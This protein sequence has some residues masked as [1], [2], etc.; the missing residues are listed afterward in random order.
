M[1]SLANFTANETK[2]K[3]IVSE[4]THVVPGFYPQFA[5]MRFI[6]AEDGFEFLG[7]P[8]SG[9]LFDSTLAKKCEYLKLLCDKLVTPHTALKSLHLRGESQ[10]LSSCCR[11][12]LEC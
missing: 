3:I 5:K 2:N 4:K 11:P 1:R 9:H 8:T 7:C 12:L 10:P 6:L